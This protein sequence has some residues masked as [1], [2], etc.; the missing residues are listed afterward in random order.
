MD[1]NINNAAVPRMK[2]I[3]CLF[4]METGGA[5][6]LTVE[7]LNEMS[8]EHDVSLI[9][10]NN[11][12]NQSLLT[13]LNGKISIFY[14]NRREASRNPI[15]VIRLNLL[16]LR[17]KPDIIHCHEPQ[18]ARILRLTNAKLIHTIHD[19]GL[20]TS[21]YHLYDKLIAI[22]GVVHQDVSLR[23]ALPVT[24]VDNGTSI[25]LFKHRTQYKLGQ[26]ETMKFIQISRLVHEKKGQDILLHALSLIKSAYSFSN[27]SVD[28][29]GGG[30]SYDYLKKL[31]D[32]LGLSSNVNFLG[33]RNRNWLFANLSGYHIL[34][35]PSKY[36]GFGLTVLEG[37]AAGLP[38]LAADIDGPAEIISH[39]P[40][41]FLFRNGNSISCAQELYN[42]V[43]LYRNNQVGDLIN[44]TIT[45][46]KQRYS[47]RSCTKHYLEEY[48]LL[49]YPD[50]YP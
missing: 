14:I 21:F 27:F 36:E 39:A 28:F 12:F 6:V 48:A 44:K 31:V 18:I 32:K 47:I 25:D 33:E 50:Y 15:P 9:I 7:L 23:C 19:V 24:K 42:I 4:T 11:K 45:M 46:I 5:Q 34:V 3:H 29:I 40:G 1:F 2:I 38:V 49:R 26:N 43:E 22:S 10:I 41:G 20:P 13:Q 17:L 30:D 8:K 37:F 35:Q 16:L